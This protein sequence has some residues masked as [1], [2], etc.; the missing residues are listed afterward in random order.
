MKALILS[1]GTGTRLRPLTY[2]I[3]K[4]LL[5]VANKPILHYIIEKVAKAGI[6][7]VGIIVGNTQDEI[8]LSVGNG[9]QWNVNVTYIYQPLPLGLAHAVKTA[10]DFLQD[11][12]FLMILGDNLFQMELDSLIKSFRETGANASVLLHKIQ[13]PTGFGVAVVENGQVVRLVEKPSEPISDLIITGVYLFDK[14]I[15]PAIENTKPSK[16]GELEITDAMQKLLE[17]GGKMSFEIIRGWWKD[18]GKLKDILEA[19][20][21]TLGE[22]K[23]IFE[24][25]LG[26]SSTYTGEICVG[27]NVTIENS[28]L[29]GPVIVGDNSCIINSYLGPYTAISSGVKISNCEVENAIILE[30]TQIE[31]IDKKIDSSLIGRNAIIKGKKYKPNS[32][33][34]LVGDDSEV[35]V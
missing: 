3:A 4:Q 30:G 20:Q 32:N 25:P 31:N 11:S 7:E 23:S 33:S 2:T 6:T 14:S 22:I 35:Y 8:K 34:L 9:D 26:T 15:F 1:G 16:R 29:R 18:T 10:A 17:T 12:D 13:N 28:I 5:P 24:T 27:K 21:L 19:N